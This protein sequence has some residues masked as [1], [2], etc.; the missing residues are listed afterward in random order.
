MIGWLVPCESVPLTASLG[1]KTHTHTR[2]G[3]LHC[4]GEEGLILC[5]ACGGV[6]LLIITTLSYRSFIITAI[7]SPPAAEPE[8]KV[9]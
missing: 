7:C 3:D 1:R 2:A 8:S 4:G 5:P 9:T 6:F